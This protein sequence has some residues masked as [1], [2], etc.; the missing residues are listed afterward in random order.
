VAA[1]GAGR[2]RTMTLSY[3]PAVYAAAAACMIAALIVLMAR[4]R[5]STPA[6][7]ET[8]GA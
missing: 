3:D 1:Y 8:V 4:R 7:V 2:I 5:V 6:P